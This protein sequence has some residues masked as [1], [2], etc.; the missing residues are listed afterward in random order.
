[1]ETLWLIADGFAVGSI[2]RAVINAKTQVRG[3]TTTG[4]IVG[5][6]MHRAI[7]KA[8]TATTVIFMDQ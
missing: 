1:M 7:T 5:V 6:V 4:F 8:Q 2:I 3:S